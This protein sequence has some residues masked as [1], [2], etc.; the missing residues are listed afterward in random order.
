MSLIL[1]FFFSSRRRHTRSLR[2]WS[3]DVC[4]SDLAAALTAVVM[5]LRYR[6]FRLLV[7]LAGAAVLA[8]AVLI[9]I[10]HLADGQR[11]SALAA[12]GGQW[13]WLT[14]APLISPALGA[15]AVAGT[16]AAAP[17]LSR[18]WRRTAWIALW[19]AAV[20]R[21]LT[22]T[23]A[24]VEAVVAF[25]AG[26]TIGAG[27]LVLFGV[28]D[29]RAGPH[30]IAVALGSAGLPVVR[31]DPAAVEAKGSRAFVATAED[32]EPLFIKVL[33][34]DQRDADLLYR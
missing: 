17:W 30:E 4:S 15:A 7:S 11:P 23:A 19:L 21:L 13:W 16:V 1:F 10:I 2:D 20:V 28:P 12:G 9:G 18:P 22:G 14:G 24:P 3:S 25:A 34:S 8:G 27:V 33:G 26:I 31:V 32:G 6:R 29:R 5:T